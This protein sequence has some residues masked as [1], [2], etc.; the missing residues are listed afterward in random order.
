MKIDLAFEK[1]RFDDI[2]SFIR[3]FTGLNIVV[4]ATI[5]DRVDPDRR[6]DLK[7]RDQ[8]V[9]TVLSRLLSELGLAYTVTEEE[10]VLV[11]L[12]A[13]AGIRDERDPDRHQR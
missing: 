8:T 10:V 13:K 11:T 7:V 12:P 9:G 3:D 2:L 6:L 5:P 1:T 4:D